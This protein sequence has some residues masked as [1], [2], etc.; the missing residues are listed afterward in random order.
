[1]VVR[2]PFYFG[3]LV[4]QGLSP[5]KGSAFAPVELGS[6]IATFLFKKKSVNLSSLRTNFC[7]SEEWLSS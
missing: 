5:Q 6:A 7:L 1:M 3:L 4:R 2:W